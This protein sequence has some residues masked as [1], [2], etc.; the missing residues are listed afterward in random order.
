MKKFVFAA[1]AAL[2]LTGCGAIGGGEKVA[3][4]KACTES[5]ESQANCTCIADSLEKNLDKETFRMV[6]TAMAAGEEKGSQM[7]DD[8]PADK[9]GAIMGAMMSAGM[10]CMMGGME[11]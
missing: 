2:A 9:Q 5:G 10:G 6:A 8:I 7:M 1:V 4:V 3:M 11:G